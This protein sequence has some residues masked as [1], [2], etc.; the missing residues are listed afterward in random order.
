VRHFLTLLVCRDEQVRG[1]VAVHCPEVRYADGQDVGLRG[2]GPDLPPPQPGHPT[3]A[4]Q[5]RDAQEPSALPHGH[6]WVHFISLGGLTG[7]RPPP[8]YTRGKAGRNHLR[9]LQSVLRIWDFLSQI[10]FFHPGS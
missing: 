10:R 1:C 2:A 9:I 4:T 6:R 7:C 5:L 3:A 8:P